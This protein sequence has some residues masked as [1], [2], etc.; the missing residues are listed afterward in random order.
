MTLITVLGIIFFLIVILLGCLLFIPFYFNLWISTESPLES[1][2]TIIWMEGLIKK[3]LKKSPKKKPKEKKDAFKLDFKKIQELYELKDLLQPIQRFFK[4][5]LKSISIE[6]LNAH[7]EIGLSNAAYTGMLNGFLYPFL[8]TMD[9]VIPKANITVDYDYTEEKLK[10]FAEGALGLR[11][12]NIVPPVLRFIS[13][14]PS[15]KFIKMIIKEKIKR[16]S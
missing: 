13:A 9:T 12:I 10:G 7:I 8:R 3:E 5:F 16:K 1:K 15:R 11:V 6:K 14:K 2:F 4:E